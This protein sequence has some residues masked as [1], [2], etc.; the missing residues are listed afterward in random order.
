MAASSPSSRRSAS[1]WRRSLRARSSSAA[2]ATPPRPAAAHRLAG[3]RDEVVRIGSFVG[4]AAF[5]EQTQL[6]AAP[7]DERLV[8]HR[9]DSVRG[10]PELCERLLGLSELGKEAQASGAHLD[11]ELRDAAPFTEFD[12]L[13]HGRERG[14]WPAVEPRSGGEIA[15]DD[16]GLASQAL[17]ERELERTADVLHPVRIPQAERRVRASGEQT[18]ARA[19]RGSRRVRELA[20]PPRS[21]PCSCR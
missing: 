10:R 8:A 20:L 6:L 3:G 17:L 2:S 14:L 18:P 11:R 12:C 7:T 9:L 16:G 5:C 13:E 21:P 1:A 15:V 4:R 19:G